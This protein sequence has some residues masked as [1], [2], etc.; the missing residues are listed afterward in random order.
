MLGANYCLCSFLSLISSINFFDFLSGMAKESSK[1]T[2]SLGYLVC[3]LEVA[4]FLDMTC[5]S[6]GLFVAI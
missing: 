4:S 6:F 2:F 5:D 3:C 1:L